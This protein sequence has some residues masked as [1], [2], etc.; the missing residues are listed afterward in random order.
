MDPAADFYEDI[1]DICNPTKT[2]LH[3]LQDKLLGTYRPILDTMKETGFIP[4]EFKFIGRSSEETPT[5]GELIL[6]CGKDNKENCIIIY[7]SFNE[8]YPLGVKRLLDHLSRSDYRGHVHYK[9]G[10]WPNMANGDLKLVHVPFAFKPCFFKEVQAKGY[11]KVLWLDASI[12]P[13]P[14]VSLN[15]IFKMIRKIGF[16][17]QAGD[18][19]I[20]SYMNEESASAFG[21]TMDEAY[22]ILSCSAAIIGID[23]TNP[24]ATALMD[25]WYK[26]AHHPYA[27]FSDRSDQNA[28]SIL[29]HQQ[30]LEEGLIPRK[31]LGSLEHPEGS[32]FI[33][34]RHLVKDR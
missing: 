22:N 5:S 33:M 25:A 19:P 3:V 23:F 4:R 20:G 17:I 2:E 31:F 24:K 32:Y 8:R 28:L 14:E 27:F 10:G 16:F 18:H 12:L 11:K 26:A 1:L 29:I 7:S 13:S 30:G 34:D 15:A 21:L 6:N 9:I